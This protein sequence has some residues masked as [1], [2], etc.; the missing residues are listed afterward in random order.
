MQREELAAP[1]VRRFDETAAVPRRAPEQNGQVLLLV[2]RQELA[3]LIGGHPQTDAEQPFARA[4][5]VASAFEQR[6]DRRKR[7]RG[8][9]A[10]RVRHERETVSPLRLREQLAC[11]AMRDRECL[12]CRRV[13]GRLRDEHQPKTGAASAPTGNRAWS[14]FITFSS[15]AG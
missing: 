3:A 11:P 4:G 8:F 2:P 12:Y 14:C 13:G 7:P 9:V 1:R 10:A 15:L 5:A 6:L